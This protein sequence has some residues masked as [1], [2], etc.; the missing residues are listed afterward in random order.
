MKPN[1]YSMQ[2][3][4][5]NTK[6]NLIQIFAELQ[7]SQLSWIWQ[8]SLIADL[9]CAQKITQEKLSNVLLKHSFDILEM[10]TSTNIFL[11]NRLKQSLLKKNNAPNK[12]F[13]LVYIL[14]K[15]HN[16]KALEKKELI[17]RISKKITLLKILQLYLKWK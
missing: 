16:P 8:K 10:D 3:K 1:T 5:V 14:K 4:S 13:S 6:N 9:R 7:L 2:E 15:I 17:K 11:A 12:N